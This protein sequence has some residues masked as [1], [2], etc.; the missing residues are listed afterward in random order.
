MRPLRAQMIDHHPLPRIGIGRTWI[1]EK[2]GDDIDK[3]KA[4]LPMRRM[5][6]G[7]IELRELA[8]VHALLLHLGQQSLE[9]IRQRIKVR[10]SRKIRH[11]LREARDQL[12]QFQPPAQRGHCGR[13]IPH[14]AMR[15]IREQPQTRQ[16][17]R[18]ARI[19]RRAHMAHHPRG[20]EIDLHL[21]HLMRRRPGHARDQPVHELLRIIP[22]Q[23]QA[24]EPCM[25]LRIKHARPAAYLPPKQC[26]RAARHR[27][28][29]PHGRGRRHVPPA[30]SCPTAHSAKM[31]DPRSPQAPPD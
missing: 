10:P 3:A 9:A 22:A 14:R 18:A 31:P 13:Q 29:R 8:G 20:V 12:R 27:T 19:K 17:S 30:R 2:L 15:Q 5:G 24:K 1:V 28:K 25:S 16:K 4:L 7:D 11:V 26:F 23:G 6:F 21:R